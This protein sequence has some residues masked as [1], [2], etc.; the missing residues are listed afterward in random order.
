MAGSKDPCF[1]QFKQSIKAISLPNKFT[2]PFYYQPH[3]L[4]QVAANELQ[5]YLLTQ[6]D[7]QHN[8]GLTTTA[9]E[10]TSSIAIG[11]MF[12]V[13]LVRSPQGEIGYL[14]AFSGKLAEQNILPPFVPPVF[15][16]LTR[17]SYFQQ[18]SKP[19]N[20][21]NVQIEQ[22]QQDP[23]A[24]QIQAE[25]EQAKSQSA[26][27]IK[28]LQQQGVEAKKQ[29]KAQ[30]AAGQN[31]LSTADFTKLSIEL[32][33]QSVQFKQ[34]IQ[35]LKERWQTTI[36][37]LEEQQQSFEQ[38][39]TTLKQQRRQL[40][41]ALQRY[42]FSQ[43]RFLNAKL[44]TQDLND[45][46]Q[47]APDQ[48][49]P[50]GAGEC[51]APKLLQYAYTHGFTPLAMAE[52]WWGA[53][54]K[55]DV[56]KHKN[57]YPAC[58]GKCRPIL[59]HMLQGL[60]VDDDPLQQNNAE[61]LALPV[62]YQDA[63]IAIVNKPPELLSVAGKAIT[64]SVQTRVAKM[65][66]DATG[67]LI[68]HR[69]D[70]STSGLMVIALTKDANKHLQQQFIRRT[71]QKQYIALVD[72]VPSTTEGVIQLPLRVDLD[73]RPRQ[74]VCEQ[75]GKPAE[76]YWRLNQQSH[77]QSLLDLFPKTGRTHQLRVHCAHHLGLGMAIIGDDLYGTAAKR[78]HL[79]A[80]VLTFAHP[81]TQEMMRFEAAAD[82]E[83][84]SMNTND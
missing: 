9:S 44:E 62:I 14:A 51:A 68:V 32:S 46:F 5:S 11:K 60:V 76:T 53:A 41:N 21:I 55:S 58:H 56:K 70:M 61:T 48:L 15:D 33:R 49:P 79:H 81:H 72:G 19:I 84:L 17:D 6:N 66:P 52:F 39:I 31:Q 63:H 42:L 83:S 64:D 13:L 36:S 82:F 1:I 27:Q 30:R 67:P 2:F 12:G 57:F 45:L 3:P 65:F 29:R 10:R 4:C 69:L 7:W 18:Q 37:L 23:Q 50:A 40:S 34:K 80:K 73:D 43:Y 74:L 75:H 26:T 71:V 24:I 78:L 16:M 47:D 25:L 8:F 77:D 28:A 22:L 35:Q 38:Q 59:G 54:P 20:Q